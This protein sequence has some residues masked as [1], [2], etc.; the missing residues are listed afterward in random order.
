MTEKTGA[1]RR[2]YHQ[3]AQPCVAAASDAHAVIS[4]LSDDE[5]LWQVVSYGRV[6]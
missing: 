4:M 1:R 2:C 6:R 3:P 5:A